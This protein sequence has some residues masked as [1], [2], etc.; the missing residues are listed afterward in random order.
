MAGCERDAARG[1]YCRR[2]HA[3]EAFV[4]QVVRQLTAVG[5]G[6]L[7]ADRVLV[8][9]RVRKITKPPMNRVKTVDFKFSSI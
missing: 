9:D 4:L 1:L 3:D 2:T 8:C 5:E 7:D 6:V